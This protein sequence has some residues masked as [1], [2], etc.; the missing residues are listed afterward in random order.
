MEGKSLSCLP[1]HPAHTGFAYKQ[2]DCIGICLFVF[3]ASVIRHTEKTV[4]MTAV[5]Y[6]PWW[7]LGGCI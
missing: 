6:V 5:Y 3:L 1:C 2:F 4:G 7:F